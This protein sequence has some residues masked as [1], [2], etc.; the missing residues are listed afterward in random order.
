VGWRSGLALALALLAVAACVSSDR[1]VGG[2]R[3]TTTGTGGSP[4][5][6]VVGSWR[7]TVIVETNGG[8]VQSSETA[9]T[10]ET[11]LDCLRAVTLRSVT[12]GGIVD[13]LIRTCTYRTGTASLT[14]S[15]TD[16]ASSITF[17]ARLRGDTL[18]LDTFAFERVR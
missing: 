9:W 14:V 17:E 8:D 16:D 4:A 3:G 15:F 2:T 13:V 7:H 12:F 1:L 11:D 6:D 18:F 5:L 10:F